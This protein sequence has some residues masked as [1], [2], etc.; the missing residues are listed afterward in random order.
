M[1]SKIKI[2]FNQNRNLINKIKKATYFFRI[3]NY[4]SALRISTN[5]LYDVSKNIEMLLTH[6]EY[7]NE[8]QLFI[9]SDYII[10]LFNGLLNAQESQDYILLADLYDM[11]LVS[12][13]IS[14]QEVIISKEGN[15]YPIDNT[16]ID[17]NFSDSLA[18]I[19]KIDSNLSNQILSMPHPS[20]LIGKGYEVEYTSCGYITLAV[21][22]N[23]KKYYLHSNKNAPLEAFQLAHSW[24]K[25]NKDTYI[26][27]G[28][29][30]MYH[31]WE[32]LH[33]DETMH[34][35]IYESD[36]NILRLSCAYTEVANLLSYPNIKLIY[37]PDFK[38]L[39]TRLA[40][41]DSDTEFVIHHPS[42]RN[43]KDASIREKMEEYFIQYSSIKNQSHILNSNFKQNILNSVD[44]VD[45]L[46]DAFTGKDLFII[47][48]GPSLDKNFQ[49]LKNI[50]K[51]NTIILATGTVFKKLL[52]A[53]IVPDY[54]I[55]TDA[56]TRVFGQISGVEDRT[57]PMLFLSTA[58][59]KFASNYVGKKYI[60]FQHGYPKAEEFAKE[61]GYH[62]Y[63]TGGSVS[64][65][66]LDI[67]IQFGCKRIIFLGL[68][69]AYTDNF[70]HAAGTSRRNTENTESLVRI[71][72]IN[73]NQVY[74]T[75][76]LN[77]YRKWIENRI[78]NVQAMEFIDA[79]E[80]GAK[81]DGMK[82]AKLS[83]IIDNERIS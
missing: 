68:D 9:N 47:A 28:F 23:S 11:Q 16:L 19:A 24:Y 41:L 80:G 39:I 60:I 22:L 46:K 69:L 35:E 76:V 36:L 21:T 38:Q 83:E 2:I 58:N 63:Q 51:E 77:I 20:S 26:I 10:T 59:H 79:T 64:T 18:A 43:I 73:G 50:N 25:E 61:H 65:T 75:K 57:V 72:D 62:L 81:I 67:G 56:N 4:D 55:V 29:G 15:A 44:S 74:T 14:L 53:G 33:L 54:V 37:D 71:T 7:F 48:A 1:N 12:F 3:Q 30:L 27:Y 78:K 8:N 13:Y 49:Q 70:V 32:L 66:A 6:A 52:Y 82:V 31:I 40:S 42:I 34:I 5:I 17:D 45:T